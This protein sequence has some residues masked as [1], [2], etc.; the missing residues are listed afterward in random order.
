M[1]VCLFK[2][3]REIVQI[4]LLYYKLFSLIEGIIWVNVEKFF[5]VRVLGIER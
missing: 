5:E 3:Y 2:F 1:I 4:L